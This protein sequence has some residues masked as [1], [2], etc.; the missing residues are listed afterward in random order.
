MARCYITTAIIL[1]AGLGSALAIYA[2]ADEIPE[3]PFAEY[4]N[5][6]RF[7]NGVERLGGKTA[8]LAHDLSRWFSAL[9]QG[10]QLAFTVAI[11]TIVVAGGYYFIESCGLFDAS[12]KGSK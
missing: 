9:W 3:N 7:L 10:E 4:E 12:E 11:I 2:T 5:S 8:V 1:I 6:K